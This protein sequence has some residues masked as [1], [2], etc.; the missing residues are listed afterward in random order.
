M[1]IQTGAVDVPSAPDHAD[2]QPALSPLEADPRLVPPMPAPE[3][4]GAA[5]LAVASAPA[6]HDDEEG[7]DAPFV[8]SLSIS[9][10]PPGAV[11]FLNGESI[12]ATPLL[13]RNQ[14]IGS[15]ALRVELDG[16]DAWSSGIRVVADQR[17]FISAR[18]TPR[19]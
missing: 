12:G 10:S 11:V 16:Y 13:L 1:A 7:L 14:P 19:R 2:V 8:G 4:A 6:P 3:R 9:S 18:L 5:V 17:T 15:R